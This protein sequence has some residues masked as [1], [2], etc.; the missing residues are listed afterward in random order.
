[1]AQFRVDNLSFKYPNKDKYALSEV[2]FEVDSGEFILICG[3]SG[4]G[5]TTLLRSLNPNLLP[6]G[7]RFG[8]VF[9]ED[10]K[11]KDIP[12]VRAVKEIGMVFQDPEM[13]IVMDRVSDEIAFSLENIAMDPKDI[14]LRLAELSTYFGL[15]QIFD[16]KIS[17]LSG[18][19][20]QIVNLNS[21]LALRPKVLIFDEPTSRLDPIAS[22]EFLNLVKLLNE[23]LGITIIISEH[24]ID[25]LISYADKV[26]LLDNG[27]LILNDTSVNFAKSIINDKKFSN[28]LPKI[29]IIKNLIDSK[30]IPLSVKV[31]RGLIQD[32]KLPDISFS[33]HKKDNKKA[34]LEL[35][36]LSFAYDSKEGYIL[37]NI[38]LTISQGSFIGCLGANATGKSTLLK[39][40]AGILKPISGKVFFENRRIKKTSQFFEIGYVAQNPLLH[41]RFDSVKE[42][43]DNLEAEK[44]YINKLI[45][46]FGLA[47]LL[48]HH[49]YDLSGGQQ[50]I[51]AIIIA[52]A[53]KPKILLLDEPTKG[54][55]PLAKNILATHLKQLNQEGLSIVC[56]THDLDFAAE[57]IPE[58]IM[59]FNKE[60][61]FSGSTRDLLSQNNYYTTD[62]SLVFKRVNPRCISSQDVREWIKLKD[63][64]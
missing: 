41:F 17:T 11:I 49:P 12:N 14:R 26:M 5:K 57:H 35:K 61:I 27:K 13:Q 60:I 10:I 7:E 37:K 45:E 63:I 52:L 15:E 6:V 8:E 62:I 29:S 38:D 46:K 53:D 3:Q 51:L 58:S 1:M 16:H 48:N 44:S 42:E 56:A 28:F 59:V 55:D 54:L 40:L 64:G 33:D 4:S 23:Q 9:F 43:L 21:V 25:D 30:Q 22:K 36:N 20:K 24:R 19:Q 39:C 50:Q 31:A 2:S 18:G 47:D 32:E 34:L